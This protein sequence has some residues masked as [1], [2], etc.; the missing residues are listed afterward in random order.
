MWAIKKLVGNDR[1]LVKRSLGI[2]GLLPSTSFQLLRAVTTL[3]TNGFT[4]NTAH[5]CPERNEGSSKSEVSE[6][7]EGQSMYFMYS[8]LPSIFLEGFLKKS[9][10][11][12]RVD[13]KKR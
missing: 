9:E 3:R 12:Q 5:V 10:E 8:N 2:H 4:R 7:E 11:L 6:I 13:G 1:I